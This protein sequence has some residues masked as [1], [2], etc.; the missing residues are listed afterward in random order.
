MINVNQLVSTVKNYQKILKWRQLSGVWPFLKSTENFDPFQRL[1]T[2]KTFGT[3]SP[4]L[5][6]TLLSLRNTVR[7]PLYPNTNDQIMSKVK[8]YKIG[9]DLLHK[10]FRKRVEQSVAVMKKD[11][12]INSRVMRTVALV[13]G[14]SLSNVFKFRLR[15]GIKSLKKNSDAQQ[16]STGEVVLANEILNKLLLNKTGLAGAFYEIK[17]RKSREDYL[18]QIKIS[19]VYLEERMQMRIHANMNLAWMDLG[20]IERDFSIITKRTHRSRRSSFRGPIGTK[21]RQDSGIAGMGLGGNGLGAAFLQIPGVVD[22]VFTD[23]S[24]RRGKRNENLT[25][26]PHLDSSGLNEIS[27]FIQEDEAPEGKLAGQLLIDSHHASFGPLNVLK[28]SFNGIKI[29]NSFFS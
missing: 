1:E 3:T 19:A 23:M 28:S 25:L 15:A 11:Y 22:G 27:Q 12:R 26:P 13:I 10:I 24:S 6:M 14:N 4:D 21:M 29:S 18:G 17:F 7:S 8:D 9:G 16:I 2:S 20:F 5:R